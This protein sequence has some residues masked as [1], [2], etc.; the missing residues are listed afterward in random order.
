MIKINQHMKGYDFTYPNFTEAEPF[1]LKFS[2]ELLDKDIAKIKE[3]LSKAKNKFN[4]ANLKQILDYLTKTRKKV[5]DGEVEIGWIYNKNSMYTYPVELKTVTEYNIDATDYIELH[6]EKMIKLD[7]IDLIDIMAFE[8]IHRDLGYEHQDIENLLEK[9]GISGSVSTSI[10]TKFF[11]EESLSPF[12]LS[13]TAKME[14]SPYIDSVNRTIKSYFGTDEFDIRKIE[15][16]YNSVI[17]KSSKMVLD[18]IANDI[19]TTCLKKD[20]EIKLVS[21]GETNITFIV[22]DDTDIN[23]DELLE[24]STM[25]IFGRNFEI[26]PDIRV[27]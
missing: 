8:Y 23:I 22:K 5:V 19:F 11:E 15:S 13:L 18:V 4:I 3:Q 20:I 25:R 2:A 12:Y 9:C 26:K 6:N 21:I 1:T 24:N 17:N 10:M 7:F 14:D 27:L 16:K